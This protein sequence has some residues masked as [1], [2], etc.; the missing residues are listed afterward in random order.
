MAKGQKEVQQRLSIV[1][2]EFFSGN[3]NE[4]EGYDLI[5]SF[6]CFNI[7]QKSEQFFFLVVW[8]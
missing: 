8:S 6:P 4:M 7:R 3:D 1:A 5:W 2:V